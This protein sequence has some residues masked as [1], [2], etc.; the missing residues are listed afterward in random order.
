MNQREMSGWREVC[1]FNEAIQSSQIILN[2]VRARLSYRLSF[3]GDVL[4]LPQDQIILPSS[5]LI[6]LEL[7]E[8]VVRES[9]VPTQQHAAR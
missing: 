2:I 7:I 5:Y 3:I 1:S 8:A 4:Y 6:E 9:R